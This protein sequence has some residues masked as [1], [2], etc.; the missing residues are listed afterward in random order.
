MLILNYVRILVMENRR[1]TDSPELGK[2]IRAK[3]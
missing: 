1:E 2:K 3:N